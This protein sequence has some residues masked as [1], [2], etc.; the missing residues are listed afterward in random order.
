MKR[1]G[2]LALRSIIYFEIVTTLALVIGLTAVNLIRPGVGVNITGASATV[3]NDLA[4]KHVTLTGVI[5]HVVPQSF[6]EAAAN[7]EVL[8]IVFFS[9]LFGVALARTSK[10]KK[11]TMLVVLREPVG[12]HVQAHGSRDA[13]RA[14]R[15]RRGDRGDGGDERARRAAASRDAHPHAVRCADRV[16]RRGARARGA[17]RARTHSQVLARGEGALADRVLD[18]VFGGG[19]AARVRGD[20]AVRRAAAHRRLR[21]AHRL[22]VQP[23]RQHALSRGRVRVRGAGGGSGHDAQDAAAHDADAHAHEQRRRGRSARS[24]S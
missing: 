13:V 16:R 15:H 1:V 23:R 19:A 12:D 22:F 6:F 18:G 10:E 9:V 3:G 7:N 11:L 20:G 21:A 14:L 17:H 4:Q 24:D 5:E 2:K 8:Q